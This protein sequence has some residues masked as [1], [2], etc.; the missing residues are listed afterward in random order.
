MNATMPTIFSDFSM[1]WGTM[2]RDRGRQLLHAIKYA[3][4]LLSLLQLLVFLPL[5]LEH[6]QETFLTFSALMA[7]FYFT[8]T[9]LRWATLN[10]SMAPIARFLMLIQNIVIPASLFLCARLYMPDTTHAIS[11]NSVPWLQSATIAKEWLMSRTPLSWHTHTESMMHSDFLHTVL[12]YIQKHARL[13]L[14]HVPGIWY[15]FLLYMSPVFS[16]LEGLAS[17]I[18]VQAVARFSQWLIQDPHG[19]RTQKMSRSLLIRRLLQ[20]G[21]EASE[22]WQLVFLLLT[23]TV[24]VASA[25]ALVLSF[26]VVTNGRALTSAAIGA[27]VASTLWISGFALAFRKANI[28]ETSLIFAY[29]VFN[30]YQLSSSLVLGTDPVHLLQSFRGASFAAM[31]FHG[32]TGALQDKLLRALENG[33]RVLSIALETLP[34]SVIVS[35]VYRLAIMYLATRVLALLQ[36]RHV[37]RVHVPKSKQTLTEQAESAK[38]SE[39]LHKAKEPDSPSEPRHM[40]D[41]RSQSAPE[42]A[43][44]KE[45]ERKPE[46]KPRPSTVGIVLVRYSRFILITVYSHLLLLDQNHQIYWRILAVSFTLA[47]WGIELLI[48]KESNV[49]FD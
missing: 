43:D 25:V 18:V 19:K 42:S 33:L 10:T 26:D 5:S 22:A 23:A 39:L 8:I 30:V 41:E 7:A 17:L 11:P 13:V 28:V 31:S 34:A 21:I 36:V 6:S 16:L 3:A 2:L 20:L 37:Q 4:I 47:M 15:A 49:V 27:S 45:D 46:S 35:L 40:S 32:H 48:S 24:Y 12:M 44:E 29:V 1:S 38:L 14:S 9:T